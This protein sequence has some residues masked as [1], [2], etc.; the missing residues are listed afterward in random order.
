MQALAREGTCVLNPALQ[1]LRVV[2]LS[3]RPIGR[4]A[5]RILQRFLLTRCIRICAISVTGSTGSLAR[6]RSDLTRARNVYFP[7]GLAIQEGSFTEVNDSTLLDFP[8]WTGTNVPQA[9]LRLLGSGRACQPDW[10]V[11]YVR[12]IGGGNIGRGGTQFV[13]SGPGMVVTDSA[14]VNTFPHELGHTF[15]GG[16]AAHSTDQTNVMFT[17]SGSITANPPRVTTAQ[18][19]T[20][21][22]RAPASCPTTL[23]AVSQ[24]PGT[25]IQALLTQAPPPPTPAQL[26][27]LTQIEGEDLDAVA[28]NHG[29]ALMPHLLE[30]L[31]SGARQRCCTAL[32]IL[33]RTGGPVATR[34]AEIMARGA[35]DP[36]VRLTAATALGRICDH[37]AEP[38]LTACTHDP[39]PG[40]RLAGLR[41]LARFGTPSAQAAMIHCL[42]REHDSSVRAATTRLLHGGEV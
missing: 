34:A 38:V 23:A 4:E 36:V 25:L 27:Q 6:F 13:N 1:N 26:A 22:Q 30:T 29:Q 17:P 37:Q 32:E 18:C 9:A 11:F 3:E 33:G 5:A 16:D 15:L 2:P 42:S 28:A 40:V 8:D 7:C 31:K 19:S 35:A 41:G 21:A 14:S 20:I 39:D 10:V 24:A 12:S